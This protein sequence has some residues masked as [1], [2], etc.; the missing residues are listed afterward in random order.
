[1]TGLLNKIHCGS[2]LQMELA[3]FPKNASKEVFTV[4]ADG[5]YLAAIVGDDDI[6]ILPELFSSP[7]VACN[8]A[9]ALKKKH[10]IEVN[11]KKSPVKTKPCK[12]EKKCILYTETEVAKL[13]HLRFKEAWLILG[14][15]GSYVS[16]VL[17]NKQ[18]AQYTPDIAKAQVFKNFED[19]SSYAKTLDMVIRKGHNLR[20]YF[21]QNEEDRIG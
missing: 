1:M 5:V 12:V 16:E 15:S 20:R 8:K 21:V 17:K 19:A 14:P 9:R 10:K 6:Y 3:Q 11:L 4:K 18:V 2:T 7:L 13:T